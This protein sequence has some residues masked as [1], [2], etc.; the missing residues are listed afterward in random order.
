LRTIPFERF[1]FADPAFVMQPNGKLPIDS[2]S[3]CEGCPLRMNFSREVMRRLVVIDIDTNEERVSGAY[4]LDMSVLNG[5]G[6]LGC[7]VSNFFSL[8]M[9][10]S[11]DRA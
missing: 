2:Q 4:P 7:G 10:I 6:I 3:V 11:E 8:Q 1:D 9:P 5:I